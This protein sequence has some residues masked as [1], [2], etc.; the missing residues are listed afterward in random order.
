MKTAKFAPVVPLTPQQK[1]KRTLL[2]KHMAEIG[3][4]GGLATA[5]K[6]GKKHYEKMMLAKKAKKTSKK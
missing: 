2:R 4:L 6:H 1:R 5:K 3:R